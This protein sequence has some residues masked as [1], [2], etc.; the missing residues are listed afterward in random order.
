MNKDKFMYYTWT[1]EEYHHDNTVTLTDYIENH[2]GDEFV[3]LCQDGNY[4]EVRCNDTLS[5]YGV[6]AYGRGDSFN[7]EVKF[8]YYD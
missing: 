2:M 4:A 8:E 6:T 3:L 5:V 1:T 7:H